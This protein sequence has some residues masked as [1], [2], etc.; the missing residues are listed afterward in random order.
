MAAHFTANGTQRVN[1]SVAVLRVLSTKIW[2]WLHVMQMVVS[3]TKT[4]KTKTKDPLENEDPRKN[5]DPLENEDPRK[6]PIDA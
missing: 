1:Y 3:K 5:E 6:N 2:G 4:P